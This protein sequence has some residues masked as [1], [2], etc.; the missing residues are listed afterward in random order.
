VL[1]MP[2]VPGI[3]TTRDCITR[4]LEAIAEHGLTCAGACVA[5][6]DL[7]VKDHFFAFLERE[8]PDLLEEYRELYPRAYALP[9]YTKEIKSLV[10][11]LKRTLMP[12]RAAV[13]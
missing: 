2:L 3:T 6:L 11:E 7:G 9:G 10:Q 12:R 4:T 13:P 1:M 5:R 8:Y